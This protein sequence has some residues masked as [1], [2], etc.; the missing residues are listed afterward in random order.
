M[1]TAGLFLLFAI[2]AGSNIFQRIKASWEI[3]TE[4]EELIQKVQ[5]Q[6]E[7]LKGFTFHNQQLKRYGRLV[8]GNNEQL[9]QDIMQLWHRSPN[10]GHSG[11]ENT[12]RRLSDLF[13]WK[14]IRD[15]VNNYVRS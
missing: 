6:E 4:L 15:D 12:Y 2:P 8:M 3:D 13:Y 14:R 11:M 7:D 1:P 9:R 10:G 5:N